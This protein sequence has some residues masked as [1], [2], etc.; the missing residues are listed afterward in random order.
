MQQL[1]KFGDRWA[2]KLRYNDV[3]IW[4]KRWEQVVSVIYGDERPW[5][6]LEC[7]YAVGMWWHKNL[8]YGLDI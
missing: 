6:K 4:G 7:C 8:E 2:S 5:R 1:D 3:G